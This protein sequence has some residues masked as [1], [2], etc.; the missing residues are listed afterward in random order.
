MPALYKSIVA[1]LGV[2]PHK[3]RI[4]VEILDARSAIVWN[5][6]GFPTDLGNLHVDRHI[7]KYSLTRGP[8]L[9][10]DIPNSNPITVEQ[11]RAIFRAVLEA[12]DAGVSV[13]Q[14]RTDVAAKFSVTV[15]QVKEI[16]AEGMEHEWPPL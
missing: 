6:N 11:R 3:S 10:T 15:V 12:Q 9:M 1:D 16:E 7:I 8:P 4:I 5:W 14:S 13:P 2:R